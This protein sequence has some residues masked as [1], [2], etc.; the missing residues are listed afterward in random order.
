MEFPKQIQNF[1]LHDVMGKWQYKGNE[2]ASAHY[3]RIGSRMDL[4][5]RTIADKTGDQK[6]EIQLRDSYICGI[7][8]LAEALKIA[9]A[10]IEENRQFIEG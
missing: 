4:F 9:E 1:V 2:L 10:V 5:I 7:E 3:I 6:F 8:T